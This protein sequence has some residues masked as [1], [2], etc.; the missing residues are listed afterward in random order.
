VDGGNDSWP[1]SSASLRVLFFA[2]PFF[3]LLAGDDF[4]LQVMGVFTRI[5]SG[6]TLAA[7]CDEAYRFDLLC[8][9]SG[10][11]SRGVEGHKCRCIWQRQP[12][13]VKTLK[14]SAFIYKAIERRTTD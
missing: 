9:D 5:C 14:G 12:L 8:G 7:D 3:M 2:A 4:I 1:A 10:C 11:G 6:A 13:G